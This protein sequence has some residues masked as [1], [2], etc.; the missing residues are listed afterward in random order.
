MWRLTRLGL[1]DGG[2]EIERL[3]H[4]PLDLGNDLFDDVAGLI[5]ARTRH[6]DGEFEGTNAPGRD[7]HDTQE[8]DLGNGNVAEGTGQRPGS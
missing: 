7:G 4:E 3:R 8:Q 2:S 1:D 5:D 6:G